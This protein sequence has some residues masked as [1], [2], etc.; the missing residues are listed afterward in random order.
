M[1]HMVMVADIMM[2]IMTLMDTTMLMEAP[3]T[4][5]DMEAIMIH[6]DI[7]IHTDTTE[8]LTDMTVMDITNT[9]VDME[10]MVT[11]V[12]IMSTL[13]SKSECFSPHF[14]MN[15]LM[16]EKPKNLTSLKL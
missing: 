12:V 3:T 16:P 7:T 4:L 1:T 11:L 9:T 14:C 10:V 8:N 13:L 2:I 6:T 5:V 15:I